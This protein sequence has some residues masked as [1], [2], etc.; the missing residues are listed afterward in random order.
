MFGS[1]KM[2]LLVI[3]GDDCFN[4]EQMLIRNNGFSMIF[5]G[6]LRVFFG[7]TKNFM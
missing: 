7:K 4:S 1:K 5:T 6:I 2:M 3:I